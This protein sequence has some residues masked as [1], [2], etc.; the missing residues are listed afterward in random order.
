MSEGRIESEYRRWK[1]VRRQLIPQLKRIGG[2]TG[3][4][5]RRL[6]GAGAVFT[7]EAEQRTK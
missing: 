7:V 6:A 3:S 1:E 5:I 2:L 4:E